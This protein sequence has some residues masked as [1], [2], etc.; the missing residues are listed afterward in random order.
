MNTGYVVEDRSA[1]P[2]L[3]RALWFIFV[4]IW[5]GGIVTA[6]AWALNVTIIGL[7]LGLWIINRIPVVMTLRPIRQTL[8]RASRGDGSEV[9]RLSNREQA[10]FLIR[11]IWFLLVG[12]WLSGLWAGLAYLAAVTIIGLPIAYWMYNRLPAVTTLFHYG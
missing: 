7:P 4:G 10:P 9:V 1:P 3:L 5:L 6:A 2:L 12:W 8:T 11:A